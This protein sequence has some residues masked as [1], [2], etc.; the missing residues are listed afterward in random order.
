MSPTPKNKQAVGL[1]QLPLKCAHAARRSQT[2]EHVH[3]NVP[4]HRPS[5]MV[6][7]LSRHLG[8]Q[9]NL[10]LSVASNKLPTSAFTV[11]HDTSSGQLELWE[12]HAKTLAQAG[13]T[14]P[15][16]TYWRTALGR[17]SAHRIPMTPL[18]RS[19]R[20]MLPE[21]A[22]IGIA[23]CLGLGQTAYD[24]CGPI[25]IGPGPLR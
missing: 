17:E 16:E 25:E 13:W 23:S 21:P 5:A 20:R 12:K 11:A 15:G 2:N 18:P 22:S 10:S 24:A 9:Q 4:W 7:S 3:D 1:H 6:R 8:D 19:S 14:S